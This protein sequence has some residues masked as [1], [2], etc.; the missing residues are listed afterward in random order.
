MTSGGTA[1][2]GE[3]LREAE[4]AALAD[5]ADREAFVRFLLALDRAGD[6]RLLGRAHFAFVLL[7]RTAPN[8]EKRTRP[9]ARWHGLRRYH[10][11][12]FQVDLLRGRRS[13]LRSKWIEAPSE[14]DGWRHRPARWHDAVWEPGKR[15]R[16]TEVTHTM[17]RPEEFLD[18][19]LARRFLEWRP[20]EWARGGEPADLP[21]AG[22]EIEAWEDEHD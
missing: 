11:T 7:D 20:P 13:Y 17:A 18:G 22:I 6:Q 19:P 4:R 12:H 16:L 8:L 9:A 10:W 21:P 2:P 1:G 3:A 5:P 14:P 15:A